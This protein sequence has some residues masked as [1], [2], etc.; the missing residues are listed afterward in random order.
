M[1]AWSV[2]FGTYATWIQHPAAGP[3][4]HQQAAGGRQR[5]RPAGCREVH[6]QEGYDYTGGQQAVPSTRLGLS[7]CWLEMG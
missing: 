6:G 4:D 2:A 3:R 7:S 1:L 5:R